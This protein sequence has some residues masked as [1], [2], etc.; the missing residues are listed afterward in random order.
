MENKLLQLLHKSFDSP[1]RAG[2]QLLLDEGLK[3]SGELRE[4]KIRLENL[5]NILTNQQYSFGPYFTVKVMN[6]IDL[7]K[8][9]GELNQGIVFAFKRVAIPILAAAIIL[10]AFSIFNTG[11]FTLD[12]LMGLDSL[13][14]Q[15]LS[16]FLLFNY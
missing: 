10:I 5:R 12:H 9:D 8:T 4:E 16:D 14:P 7:L 2:E 15:Y 13:Q 11:S 6:K 1:L 3:N